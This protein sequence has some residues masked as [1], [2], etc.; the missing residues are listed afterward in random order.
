MI[1][2]KKN[3]DNTY[4]FD[5]KTTAGQTLLKSSLFP[6]ESEV[7]NVVAKLPPLSMRQ[8]SFERKTNHN[9]MFHFHLK[10]TNGVVLGSSQLYRSEAGMENGIKNLRKRISLISQAKNL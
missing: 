5:L 6:S 7:K 2:I 9:G 10:D 1:A 4:Q 8:T 3:T